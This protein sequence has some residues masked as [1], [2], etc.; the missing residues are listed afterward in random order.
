MDPHDPYFPHPYDGTGIA[1][2]SNQHPDE[3]LAAEM[4][5]LYQGEIEFLDANFGEL[6]ARLEADGIYDDTVIVL[7]SDHGEEFFE[8]GGW[9]HGTSLYDEQ[10][11]VPFLV[12]WAKGDVQSVPDGDLGR[13]SD[14]APTLISR[15]AATV[16]D[17]MQGV[18]VAAGNRSAKDRQVFAEEDHEG[19]VMWSIQ[20][21]G[22]KLIITNSENPRGLPERE[23]FDMRNDPGETNNLSGEGSDTHEA[24][25]AAHAELQRRFAAGEAVSGGGEA[26]MDRAQCEQLKNL[27]YVED[28]SHL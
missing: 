13:M 10:I 23:L 15:T 18:D 11:H 12:K 7:V 27:G 22:M 4:Q 14:V 24:S 1:R 5:A 3:A 20:S 6:L 2:V 9:W 26:E 8:H 28:C 21:D 25:L 16:P 17:S 19:N